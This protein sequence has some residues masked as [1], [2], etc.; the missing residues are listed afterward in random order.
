MPVISL[1]RAN[2]QSEGTTVPSPPPKCLSGWGLIA[3]RTRFSGRPGVGIEHDPV[4]QEAYSHEVITFGFWPGEEAL[5]VARYQGQLLARYAQVVSA[6]ER[7][8]PLR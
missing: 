4:R 7:Q 3:P 8:A 2:A 5:A 1:I 6:A